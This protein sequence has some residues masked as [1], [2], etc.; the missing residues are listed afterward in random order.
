MLVVLLNWIYIIV[1]MFVVGYFLL[2]R[3]AVLVGFRKP[4]SEIS[5]IIFGMS[6]LT[7]YAGYF[8]IFYRVGLLANVLLL[9]A[10]AAFVWLDRA[11]YALLFRRLKGNFRLWQWIIFVLIVLI[12]LLFTAYGKFAYDT[13]LYHAQ[14]IRWIEEYGVVKGLAYMQTRL[15]FNSAYFCL[16]ALY[17]FHDLGQ[18]LHTLSGFIAAFT[19]VYAAAGFF[20]CLNNKRKLITAGNFVRLAPFI[21][22][23]VICQ[24]LISP[25]TDFIT[26]YLIIWLSIRW[27]EL[28]EDQEREIAP[29][30]FLCVIAVFLVSIKLSVGVLALLVIKPAFELIREKRVKEIFCYLILGIVLILPYFIRNVLIS[31]WLVYPFAGIDLF[32]ADWRVPASDVRYEADEIT[33]WARY[34]KDAKLINQTI[35]EWFP[36]WWQ[37]QGRENR[38]LSLAAFFACGLEMVRLLKAFISFIRKK[39]VEGSEYL[40]FEVIFLISFLFWLLSAPSNRFGYSYLIVLPLLV[41]GGMLSQQKKGTVLIIKYAA[42]AVVTGTMVMGLFLFLREDL[43]YL[44]DHASTEFLVKQKDY[45]TVETGSNDFE[46]LTVYYPLEEGAQIWY[47]AFPAIL[48]EGNLE[49]I[50]RRGDSVRDGFRLKEYRD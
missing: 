35:F 46:G 32:S 24:E 43:Y 31:G 45:P 2:K 19:M 41:I 40:Y 26:I 39:T 44:K 8:S 10:C 14:S 37:E 47:H 20:S 12:S 23:V 50:E 48:Y 9:L 22:F 42:S 4:V 17:S 13:G 27:I 16:C 34:T 36:V 11:D 5:C 7:A 38:Y 30:A 29:Y 3:G 6:V 1:T 33:V 18:S 28:L 25:T 15:A 49:S 21:Y